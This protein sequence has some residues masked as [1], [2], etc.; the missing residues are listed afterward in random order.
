MDAKGN[1]TMEIDGVTQVSE[2]QADEKITRPYTLRPLK[3]KD[4]FPLLKILRKI[5]RTELKKIINT[6][7]EGPQDETVETELEDLL[8]E[9][10]HK[11]KD[12]VKELGISV[13]LELADVIITNME[14]MESEIYAFWSELSG[15]PAEEIKEMEFG[16]LPLMIIDTFSETRNFAFFKVLSKFLK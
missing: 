14:K 10:N 2:N 1:R 8:Q 16:T 3:D 11:K 6:V 5:D 13:A 9:E 15:V 7:T 4:M 12:R